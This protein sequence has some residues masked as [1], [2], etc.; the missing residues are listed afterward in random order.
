MNKYDMSLTSCMIF[1]SN[2]KQWASHN[3]TTGEE[4]AARHLHEEVWIENYWKSRNDPHRL[5]LLEKISKYSPIN[6]VL[7]IGCASGPN[8]Y[9]IAKRFPDAEIRG[10]DIN[11]AAVKKGN[12]WFR[13]EGIRNV[14]LEVGKA[15][16]LKRFADKSFDIV[17]TDAVLIYISPNEVRKVVKEMLR[18]GHILILN[19]WHIFNNLLALFW[20]A[21]CILK[22]K[23][24]K[25]APVQSLKNLYYSLGRESASLGRFAGHWIRNYGIL[26]SEFVSEEKIFITKL[27]KKMW[28]DKGW[29]RWGAI[30]EVVS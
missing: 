23:S 19:E 22:P 28:N 14:K 4:W 16:G 17:L 1:M 20:S 26:F 9:N 2:D 12:V 21:Y 30:V 29:Q 10:I 25:V 27:P 13:Q 24:R 11:P 7:E 8:L 6:S 3:I 5:F 18:I 15:Q